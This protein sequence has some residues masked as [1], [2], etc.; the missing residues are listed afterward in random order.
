M[1][2]KLHQNHLPVFLVG[3]G[4]ALLGD[5]VLRAALEFVIA[6]S[7]LRLL[8]VRH[9]L[10]IYGVELG[11]LLHQGLHFSLPYL[12]QTFADL[13]LALFFL[14]FLFRFRVTYRDFNR[15]VGLIARRGVSLV[16]LYRVVLLSLG[17]GRVGLE[18]LC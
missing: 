7:V 11:L 17:L 13:P 3:V 14:A 2:L 4:F 10:R 16:S 1:H 15:L 6:H 8:Q 18:H 5:H 12:A 9:V